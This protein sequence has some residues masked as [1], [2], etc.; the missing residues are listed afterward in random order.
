MAKGPRCL[1]REHLRRQA[2]PARP[3]DLHLI[4][5]DTSG[6]MHQKGRLALAKGHVSRLIEQAAR[7][8]DHV[9]LLSCGGQGVALQLPPAPARGSAKV[10]LRLLGGGGGTPLAAALRQADRLLRQAK[11][12]P[13][14]TRPRLGWLWLLTDGRTLE[15][16]AAPTGADRIVILDF[17][18]ERPAIGRC[19]DWARAWRAEHH[20]ALAPDGMPTQSHRPP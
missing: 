17:D 5:L 13:V 9:A 20:R 10:Q 11:G 4:V 18:S 8:G 1:Q 12:G 6:S 14:L 19:P 3:P 16:P 2:R 7:C 15:Q